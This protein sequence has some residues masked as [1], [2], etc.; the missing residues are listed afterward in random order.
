LLYDLTFF[1]R[2]RL[3]KRVLWFLPFALTLFIIPL[4]ITGLDNSVGEIMGNIGPSSRG[5]SEIDRTDYLFTQMRVHLTYL[6]LLVLPVGQNINHEYPLYKSF[7]TPQ[8]FLSFL[9]LLGIFSIGIY[10]FYKSR[11]SDR[12]LRI[13]AFGIFFFFITLSVESSVIPI[14]MVINE[15]RLYLPS[16]GFYIAIASS[17]S[18]LFLNFNMN[19]KALTVLIILLITIL[20]S[21]TFARNNVWVTRT[22][23]WE[24]TVKKSSHKAVAHFNLASAYMDKRIYK[25]ALEH[26]RKTIE[27]DPLYVEA[28]YALGVIHYLSGKIEKA[29]KNYLAA[30]KLNPYYAEANNNLGAIY[31]ELGMYKEAMRHLKEALKSD[32]KYPEAHYNLAVSYGLMNMPD[33]AIAHLRKTITVKPDHVKAHL[34]LGIAFAAKGIF[35]ISEAHFMTALNLDPENIKAKELLDMLYKTVADESMGQELD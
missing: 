14:P 23:L 32:P 25:K 8:V 1:G 18:L 27:L 6:R 17:V 4:S 30:L 7:L 15:Y 12:A 35:D 29:I 28:Y 22:E 31:N 5:Y 2:E 21:A 20:S 34:N 33:N 11:T 19:R 16:L 24:D 9:I 26:Y 3:L 13:T 10:S